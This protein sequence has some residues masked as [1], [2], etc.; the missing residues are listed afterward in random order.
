MAKVLTD[1]RHF[2]EERKIINDGDRVLIAVSGGPDS[3]FLFYFFQYLKKFYDIQFSVAYIHHHLRKEAD[4]ELKFVENLVKKYKVPFYSKDIWIKGKTG[5]EEKAR[6]ARYKALYSTAKKYAC[7]K[8]AVGHTLDDNVETIIMR[9]VKG[10][11]IAGLS[12]ISPEKNLFLRSKIIVIRPLLCIEKQEII[13]FLKEKGI[14]YRIDE[15]NLST[16]FFRNRVRLEIIPFLLKYNPQ[17]KK[18]LAQMSFLLQDD[19]S[20]LFRQGYETLKKIV[21]GDILDMVEYRKLDISLKRIV[22]GILIEKITGDPYRS[23]NKIKQ[24]VAYLTRYPGKKLKMTK[25][26][27]VVRSR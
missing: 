20:F 25:I 6:E 3:V 2:V 23:Y 19:F 10:T 17:F 9:F 21:K 1:V 5:I 22:A 11:G 7:N 4:E 16:D 26:K 12:G 13:K 15:T 27:D 24:L 14:E 18:K 8:I